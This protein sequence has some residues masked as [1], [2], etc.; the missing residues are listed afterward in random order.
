MLVSYRERVTKVA[1]ECSRKASFAEQLN[2]D[3]TMAWTLL[4]ENAIDDDEAVLEE[5]LTHNQSH[6]GFG[7]VEMHELPKRSTDSR[8]SR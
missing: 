4:F 7:I 5:P 3:M 2:C 1:H 8:G 6:A